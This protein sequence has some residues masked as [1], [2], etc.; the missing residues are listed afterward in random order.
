MTVHVQSRASG[1]TLFGSTTP[2]VERKAR[3]HEYLRQQPHDSLD[4]EP[5]ATSL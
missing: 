3:R 1:V 4:H 2:G 5:E